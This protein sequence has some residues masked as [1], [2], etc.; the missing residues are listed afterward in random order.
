MK[1]NILQ[2]KKALLALFAMLMP[3]LASAHD[4]ELDGVYYNIKS[5]T[6]P[7]VEVT[8]RGKKNYDYEN[9]YSGEVIIP[10][11]VTYYGKNYRVTGI[12]NSAFY[13]CSNITSVTIPESVTSIGNDAFS[14]C[15]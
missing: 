3:L 7:T 14:Y 8:F 2:A 6:D 10:S 5:S 12:G 9:E 15:I 4:F 1:K 11:T 13:R